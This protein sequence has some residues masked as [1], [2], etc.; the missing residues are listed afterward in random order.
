MEDLN[1]KEKRILNVRKSIML[2]GRWNSDLAMTYLGPI[3]CNILAAPEKG[4]GKNFKHLENQQ[5]EKL[6]NYLCFSI[7]S[8]VVARLRFVQ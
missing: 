1:R 5:N 6:I 7:I 3:I 2:G 4:G 8:D